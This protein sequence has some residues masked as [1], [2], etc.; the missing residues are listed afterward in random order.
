MIGIR[1]IIITF[2]TILCFCS[3]LLAQENILDTYIKEGL[4]NNQSLKQK[5][6]SYDKSLLAL[7]EARGLFL[8]DISLNARYSIANGGRVIEFPVGDMLNPVYSTLN[9]MTTQMY[10]LGLADEVFPATELEN[11]EIEFLRPHEQETKLQLIQPI[12][13]PQVFF[14][15]KIKK[16][17]VDIKKTD[18]QT[19]KRE[20]V[21]EIKKAYYSYIKTEHFL[22]LI[23]KTTALANE[24][25]RVNEKLFENDKV[26]ID[27]VYRSKSELSKLEQQK[28]EIVK[29]NK[30]SKA[31]FNFL[32]NK[33]LNSD[34]NFVDD[35]IVEFEN[36][37]EQAKTN[38]LTNR[39][40]FSKLEIYS[41]I[42]EKNIKLNKFNGLPTLTGAVDYGFQGEEYSFTDDDDFVLA[43]IVLRWELFKGFQNKY[44]IQQAKIDSYILQ[45]KDEELKNQIQLQVI[46]S[47]YDIEA[48]QKTLVSA[49]DQELTA[50]KA[51]NIIGKKYKE[52]QISLLE[53][54]DAR[55]TMTN[56]QQNVIIRKYDL[57]IK[58]AEFERITAMYPLN[59]E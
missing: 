12:F 36:E 49:K 52:G 7:K 11:E 37:L 56:A 43:S 47:Y 54:I 17:L 13:N 46:N 16:D 19:Y 25:I 38:A 2:L 18:V 53:Y 39:E 8:P 9:Q 33:P 23:D 20:L 57:K 1:N 10:A 45:S 32:L 4:E 58:Y 48:S 44:K 42:N 26:T 51:Y 27:A 34:I 55:T 29:N 21:A 22:N 30:S 28:A 5:L 35:N 40:E 3:S 50:V 24:N 14:N 41:N 59:E 15:Y 6:F 31:Y